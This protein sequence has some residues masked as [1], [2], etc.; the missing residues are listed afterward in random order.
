[1]MIGYRLLTIYGFRRI[2]LNSTINSHS[3]RGRFMHSGQPSSLLRI[4]LVFLMVVTAAVI[5]LLRINNVASSQQQ[6][7]QDP[8]PGNPSPQGTA[9][10]ERKIGIGIPK[11]LPLKFEVRNLNSD[12][13][14]FDLEIDVTN[15]ST[16]PI[17]RLDFFITMPGYK[18]E[19]TGNKLGFWFSYGRIQLVD[20]AEPVLADDIPIAPGE[21]HTFKI[22]EGL[23][24]GWEEQSKRE[25]RP[26]PK[27][28]NLQFE[29]L[30]FGDGT[31]FVTT[32]GEPVNIHKKSGGTGAANQSGSPPRPSIQSSLY[33]PAM[34]LPVNFS[35]GYDLNNT[36]NMLTGLPFTC[37]GQS[38]C[39]LTKQ[40][41]VTCGRTCDPG[42]DQKLS[43][44]TFGCETDPQCSCRIP[45]FIQ[46]SCMDPES[47]LPLTCTNV[48]LY[49][50]CPACGAEGSASTC[51]DGIDNDGDGF[52][53]CEE[54]A[55]GVD[56]HCQPPCLQL[57]ESCGILLPQ[58]CD[59]LYCINGQCSEC[60]IEL[61]ESGCSWSCEQQRCV[62]GNCDSPVLVDVS[63]N[64][65]RLTDAKQGV[66]FDLN[67]DGVRERLSGL[68]LS[69]TTHF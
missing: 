56:P 1:M 3:E 8:S 49:P 36:H 25:G 62:G 43:H 54:T 52:T 10:R 32:A 51:S 39:Q 12:R 59:N 45:D 27:V 68:L 63:G 9:A 47:G 57:G 4:L 2:R 11:H 64:G 60:T 29:G 16:K 5:S 66:N 58:C 22:R 19:I 34:F 31:G 7:Q 44:S 20:L 42:S 13:W 46:D 28:L 18:S 55:C 14:V 65:F 38:N 24:K 40:T 33:L 37:G 53:D 50:C 35:K 41:F 21:K 48:A 26:E 15:T 6:Q 69:Q 30:N 67:D 61:C 23:A 17:Y